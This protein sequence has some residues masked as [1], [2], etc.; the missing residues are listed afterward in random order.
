MLGCTSSHKVFKCIHMSY[1]PYLSLKKSSPVGLLCSCG[2]K[3][4]LHDQS[5]DFI[6]L[7]GLDL[8][9]FTLHV[10]LGLLSYFGGVYLLSA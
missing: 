8:Y 5:K 10:L 7:S 3:F 1:K 4:S 6:F 2:I 9:F